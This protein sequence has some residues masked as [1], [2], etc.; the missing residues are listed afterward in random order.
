MAR[1]SAYRYVESCRRRVL[2]EAPGG[3][4]RVG[5]RVLK[6]TPL[7]RQGFG[8]SEVPEPRMR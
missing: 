1:W 6:L 7:T 4:F 8:L 2:E 5:L 3:G